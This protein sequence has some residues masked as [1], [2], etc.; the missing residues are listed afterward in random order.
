MPNSGK[1]DRDPKIYPK[2]SDEICRFETFRRVAAIAPDGRVRFHCRQGGQWLNAVL[3][4]T[5][6]EWRE[7][8]KD[9]EVIYVAS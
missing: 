2:A 8:A 3:T 6:D 9:A 7:L 5:L 1:V 4:V